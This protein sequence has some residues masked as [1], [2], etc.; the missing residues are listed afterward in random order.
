MPYPELESCYGHYAQVDTSR[1][2]LLKGGKYQSRYE[3]GNRVACIMKWPGVIPEGSICSDITAGFD[4]FT[5]FAAI[6]GAEIP[7][8][9]PIDG[10]DLYPLMTNNA[11]GPPP[12]RDI[13]GYEARGLHMSYREGVWK[14][15][16]PTKAVYG[17]GALDNY[18]LYQ[19]DD[20]P[21]E[22]NNVAKQYPFIMEQMIE[23]AKEFDKEI[24]R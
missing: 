23:K 20:D 14:L 5:T 7:T 21:G 9:R 18:E 15:A 2:H 3:G 24:K 10:R 22:Q 4:L 12:H 13:A 6:A 8:D 16:I 19:L 1:N 11:D 17:V